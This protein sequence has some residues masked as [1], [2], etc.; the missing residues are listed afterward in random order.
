MSLNWYT[1]K[2]GC[3]A[4]TAILEADDPAWADDTL[5]PGDTSGRRVHLATGMEWMVAAFGTPDA[6][7]N[8]FC[9]I[10]TGFWAPALGAADGTSDSTESCMSRYGTR[11]QIGTAWEYTNEMAH[12]GAVY[13]F[14]SEAADGVSIG[15][16]GTWA[17]STSVAKT[18]SFLF[19]FPL[20]TGS[21]SSP[22]ESFHHA[23]YLTRPGTA[24]SSQG[25]E[26]IV[27]ARG[28]S[29]SNDLFAGRFALNFNANPTTGAMGYTGR[30]ALAAP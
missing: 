7:G 24:I 23:D 6:A 29:W 1:F 21:Q 13:N 25:A 27:G 2:H 19:H 17:F 9:N 10:E 30:C 16:P 28:A 15:I 26:S 11:N 4:R 12:N 22:E 5:L 14:W 3:D 18:W 20:S 8:P